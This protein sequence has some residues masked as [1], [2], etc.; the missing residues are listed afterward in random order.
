MTK[1]ITQILLYS[2]SAEIGGAGGLV[3]LAFTAHIVGVHF[4]GN[5]GRKGFVG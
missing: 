5:A 1:F 4:W 2:Q 3:G